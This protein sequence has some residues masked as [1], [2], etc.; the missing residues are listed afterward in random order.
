MDIDCIKTKSNLTYEVRPSLLFVKVW[1]KSSSVIIW[2]WLFYLEA[3][4]LYF[5][6]IYKATFF[7]FQLG[8]QPKNMGE[9]KPHY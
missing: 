2:Y 9:N 5:T 1:I 4:V 3:F 7:G 6:Q 8:L